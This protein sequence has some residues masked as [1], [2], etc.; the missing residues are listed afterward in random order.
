[1]LCVPTLRKTVIW[2]RGDKEASQ[3][4][5]GE[6]DVKG[7]LEVKKYIKKTKKIRTEWSKERW[8]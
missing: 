7:V 6:L 3:Q 2:V 8:K 1:M 5:T 4:T